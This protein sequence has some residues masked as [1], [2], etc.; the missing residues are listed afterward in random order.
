M[1]KDRTE[2]NKRLR[3]E[4][5]RVSEERGRGELKGDDQEGVVPTVTVSQIKEF[6]RRKI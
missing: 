4:N 3:D 2:S 5:I 1:P 6:K